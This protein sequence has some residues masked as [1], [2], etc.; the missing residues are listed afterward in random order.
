LRRAGAAGGED[1]RAVFDVGEFD[2]RGFDQRLL[3]RD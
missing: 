3:V 2:Q 1:E